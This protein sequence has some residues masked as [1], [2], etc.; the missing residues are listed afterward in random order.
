L[1]HHKIEDYVSDLEADIKLIKDDIYRIAWAMRGGVSSAD[2]F[3]V[4]SHEDRSIM[5]KIIK[6]NIESTKK[7]GMPLI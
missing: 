3:H 6:E 4:Y 1:G 7:S 2:L 5:G